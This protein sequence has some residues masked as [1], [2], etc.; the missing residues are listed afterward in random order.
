MLLYCNEFKLQILKS[1]ILRKFR[2][3]HGLHSFVQASAVDL[4]P[5]LCWMLAK[6]KKQAMMGKEWK[7][8]HNNT[9]FVHKIISGYFNEE[10]QDCD[11]PRDWC[12][13]RADDGQLQFHLFVYHSPA[14]SAVVEEQTEFNKIDYDEDETIILH[15]TFYRHF[16]HIIRLRKSIIILIFELRK[17]ESNKTK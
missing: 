7:E 15:L 4:K 8:N 10:T 11:L 14:H 6:V 2:I 16:K 13:P 17:T 12:V 1:W 9:F 5:Y 3:K